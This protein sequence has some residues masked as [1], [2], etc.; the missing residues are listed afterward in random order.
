MDIAQKIQSTT[1]SIK[2]IDMHTTGEPT[3]IIYA[4]FPALT[5]S[6]LLDKRDEAQAHHDHIRKRLMHEPR[7]HNDMYGAILVPETE[8]VKTGEAHIGVLFTH[9][10]GFS[11]MCGHATIA[12]G[13]FLVDT[14]DLSVF[15]RR[16][17]VVVDDEKNEVEV[18][19]H[20]PCGLVRVFVPVLENGKESD[21]GRAVRFLSS[22]GYV[23][24]KGI[25]VQVPN[26]LWEIRE[27]SVR[28]DVIYGGA[29]YAR[30]EARDLGVER[31]LDG[32]DS[33][34]K[35]MAVAA[36][37][38]KTYLSTH[39]G[40]LN[41]LRRV[42]DQRLAFLYG[43]MIVDAEVG[44]R[45]EGVEGTETGVCFFGENDQVDRSPTG[46]CVT[47]R[48]ALAYADGVKL[49]QRRAYNSLVSNRFS[50]G[51][52]VGSIVEDNV[53]MRGD[54]EEDI[55]SAV[56]VQV[57]GNAYYTGALTFVH[58]EGDVTSEAGFTLNI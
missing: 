34:M 49:G 17:V 53:A 26:E 14:H 1:S 33:S 8:Y 37:K 3:R 10:G 27:R 28:V 24:G 16:N 44:H 2:C 21:P 25:E 7:G 20:A 46:S 23:A 5:G 32:D 55:L 22:P 48:M 56:I 50:T 54:S 9:S 47:A 36:R 31:G 51:A 11:T 42:E 15:P 30:V 35:G 57:E 12:L 58:E 52:F 41:A 6:T 29:F 13:R 4:G 45:P 19:I 43:V 18:V 39:P 40:V 38:L